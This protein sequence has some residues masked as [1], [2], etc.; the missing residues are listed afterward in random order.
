[1]KNAAELFPGL[2]EAVHGNKILTKTQNLATLETDLNPKYDDDFDISQLM[3]EAEDPVTGTLRDLKYDDRDLPLAKN[4][5]DFAFNILG[6]DNN[7]PWAKQLWTGA[8]FFGEICP[9]CS[10][11]DWLKWSNVP[12]DYNSYDF[13]EH[14]QFLEYGVCPKC[15]R[16]KRGLIKNKL[17]RD[18]R[19]LVLCWGQRSGKSATSALFASYLLHRYLKFPKLASLAPRDMQAS[20][21]LSF[22]FVALTFNKAMTLLWEPFTNII[23]HS[24]WYS[25]YFKLLDYYGDKYGIELYNR[26]TEFIKFKHKAFNLYPSHPGY[27]VLRGDTRVLSVIDELGLFP[28]PKSNNT[29]DEVDGKQANPDEV[30]K[31]LSNSLLTGRTIYSKLIK[32][33]YF[34]APPAVMIGVSS[35]FSERDKVMRL[36]NESRTE[37]GRKTIMGLQKPTWEVNPNIDRDHP[38]VTRLYASNYEK[39]ERDFGANPPRIHSTFNSRDIIR[40]KM[41]VLKNSHRFIY[42]YKPTSISGRLIRQAN[43]DFATVIALDAGY[44]DNSF[45]ITA[46]GYDTVTGKSKISTMIEIIPN[47]GKKIDFNGVYL[48]VISPIIKECNGILLAADR[49]NSLDILSRAASDHPGLEV[50]MFSPKR[51]HFE[52]VNLFLNNDNV[53]FPAMELPWAEVSKTQFEDYRL[54]FMNSP[55]S[56][57]ASQVITVKDVGAGKAPD[58]GDDLTDDMYRATVLGLTIVNDPKVQEKLRNAKISVNKQR[59]PPAM[60]ISRGGGGMMTRFRR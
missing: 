41:F 21:P 24:S 15:K 37:E 30:H 60:Y 32:E 31:S 4:F 18:F 58:K 6:K 20:T 33:G 27:E 7:P 9:K 34:S 11:R 43:V 23:N 42:E 2:Y 45:C 56:H 36:L 47:Q 26:K 51:K 10:N 39:A 8:L 22:T 48:E 40:D 54:Y 14:I 38:D 52:A 25:E 49:W 16:T 35:P 19:E 55:V 44:S 57:F 53:V 13:P 28:L 29:D 46:T 3:R 50:K 17:I 5:Y 12:K 1:M 59:M